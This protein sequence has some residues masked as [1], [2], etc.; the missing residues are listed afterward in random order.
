[1]IVKTVDLAGPTLDWAA[2]QSTGRTVVWEGRCFTLVSEN[3][4]D[5]ESWA[6]S[7][8]RAQGIALLVSECIQVTKSGADVLCNALRTLVQRK[9]GLEIEI[10]DDLFEAEMKFDRP[11]CF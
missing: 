4:E 5:E 11:R 9:M 6:P 2:A 3:P 7:A 8:D 1:M 10:P